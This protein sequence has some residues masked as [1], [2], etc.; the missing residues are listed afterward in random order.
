MP[1]DNRNPSVRMAQ[2]IM[3]CAALI[4]ESGLFEPLNQFP[5]CHEIF[6]RIMRMLVK[7]IRVLLERKPPPPGEKTGV[8]AGVGQLSDDACP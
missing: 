5:G 7:I 3:F 4:D 6:I 2:L 1:V 8:R